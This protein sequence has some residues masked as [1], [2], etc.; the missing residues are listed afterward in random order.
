MAGLESGAWTY[1]S[2]NNQLV[3]ECDIVVDSSISDGYTLKTPARTI[4]PTKPWKLMVNT[5]IVDID[6][7]TVLVDLWAGFADDF[8]LSGDTTT[9]AATS[10]AEIASGIM[11]D[12]K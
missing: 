7:A 10:G 5:G 4:D 8:A 9:V 6:D 12:V 3:M 11:D 2:V 1:G